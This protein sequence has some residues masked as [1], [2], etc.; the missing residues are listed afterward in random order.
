M[1]SVGSSLT[2][3]R[4]YQG[5][6]TSYP[7]VQLTRTYARRERERLQK[8]ETCMHTHT[9][10]YKHTLTNARTNACMHTQTHT[11]THTHQAE[12]TKQA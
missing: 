10:P 3:C 11:H 8:R 2:R 7:G 9:H 6:V 5:F 1:W 12:N 4:V